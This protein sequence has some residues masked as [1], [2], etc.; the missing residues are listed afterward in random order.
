MRRRAA[1][2]S[3]FLEPVDEQPIEIG[4]KVGD[5]VVAVPSDAMPQRVEES[6]GSVTEA[7][8]SSWTIR[9]AIAALLGSIT[10]AYDW[11]LSGAADAGAEAVKLK[12]SFGPWDALFVTLKANMPLI[13][14]LF[15]IAGCGIVITRR[16][17][18]A[19]TGKVG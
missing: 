12:T 4:V 1:E 19:H 14:A 16:L 11:A 5:E 17:Q 2:A 10:Q 13:G 3:L 8:K 7:A 15:V 6:G 18:A 9:G